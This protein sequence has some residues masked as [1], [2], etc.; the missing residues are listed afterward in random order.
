MQ[1]IAIALLYVI[2]WIPYSI[3][4]LIQMFHY[5]ERLAYILSTFFAYL[6]YLQALLL[7]YA[8]ILFMPEIKEKFFALSIT[9]FQMIRCRR[10]RIQATNTEPNATIPHFYQT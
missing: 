8:C 1:L 6:P 5:Y 3:I 4:V 9:L 10:N 2:G 7:P